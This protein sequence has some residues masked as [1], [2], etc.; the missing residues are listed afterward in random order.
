M[1]LNV[2]AGQRISINQ[3]FEKIAEAAGRDIKP[4]HV[5]ARKGDV[6]HSLA[7]ISRTR[8]LL[9]YEPAFDIDSGLE[10]CVKWYLGS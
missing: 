2:G 9:C 6:R 5:E 4:R 10:Q 1:F 7:D 8:E 3:L